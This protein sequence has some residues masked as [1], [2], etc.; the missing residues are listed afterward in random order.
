MPCVPWCGTCIQLKKA[1]TGL[2]YILSDTYAMEGEWPLF[3]VLF[4][5]ESHLFERS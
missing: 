1:Q 2:C 5:V 3:I 4:V